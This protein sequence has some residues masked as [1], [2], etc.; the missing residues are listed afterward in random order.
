MVDVAMPP[1]PARSRLYAL[2]LCGLGTAQVESMTSYTAR[3]A[4][5]HGLTVRQLV[6]GEIWPRFAGADQPIGGRHLAASI[7]KDDARALCG[8]RGWASQWVSVLADLTGRTDLHCASLLPWANVLSHVDLIRG[9]RAWCPDCYQAWHAAGQTLY[10]P[11][12]WAI[13]EVLICPQHQRPLVAH[14]PQADCQRAQPHL[15]SRAR[16]GRCAYCGAWLGARTGSQPKLSVPDLAWQRWVVERVGELLA[17]TPRLEARPA[18]ARL[19]YAATCSL[20]RLAGGSRYRLARL[21]GRHESVMETLRGGPQA[22]SLG[23]LLR[24]CYV[25]GVTLLQFLTET[26][27]RLKPRRMP[28]RP[29]FQPK[30]RRQTSH[31]DQA[32]RAVL[33]QALISSAPPSMRAMGRRLKCDPHYL[34]RRFPELSKAIAHRYLAFR[35]AEKAKRIEQ[36]R[37]R[38]RQAVVALQ[39]AGILPS[40]NRVREYLKPASFWGNQIG[41]EAWQAA[42]DELGLAA[43]Q[44]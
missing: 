18:A 5:A 1:V 34:Y 43:R 23:T 33:E 39:R 28:A 19:A 31:D 29:L 12:L 44:P 10:D 42:V 38:I 13:Q 36:L 32:Y 7:C 3:L 2:P 41:Y 6:Q 21:I 14:C 17:H 24:L 35:Q 30:I 27:L 15:T 9:E 20:Q 40:R 22:P 4:Q 25:G 37:A 11:L 16:P 26:P 8:V